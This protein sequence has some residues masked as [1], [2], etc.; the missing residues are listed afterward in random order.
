MLFAV[1]SA[2]YSN[3]IALVKDTKIQ[4]VEKIRIFV[5]IIIFFNF[6][7]QFFLGIFEKKKLNILSHLFKPYV[8]ILIKGLYALN[9]K[10]KTLFEE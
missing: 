3:N 5:F 6:E 9:S 2:V 4:F 10:I 8:T 1:W 7:Q